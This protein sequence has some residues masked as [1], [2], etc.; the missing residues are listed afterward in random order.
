MLYPDFAVIM[1]S[2]YIFGKKQFEF[3]DPKHERYPVMI[4]EPTR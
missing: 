4:G 2:K 1:L 3:R